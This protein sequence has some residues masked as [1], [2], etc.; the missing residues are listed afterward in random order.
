[1]TASKKSAA[2]KK[3]T[4]AKPADRSK[5]IAASWTDKKVAKA[6]STKN[7]VRVAG[8]DYRSCADAFAQ[9]GLPMGSMVGFRMKLKA[10]GK[11]TFE[12]EGKKAGTVEKF[13]FTLTE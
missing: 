12:V 10:S 8:V 9:L 5:A 2:A 1:M 4:K 13:V 7:G 6:R 11:E 3:T